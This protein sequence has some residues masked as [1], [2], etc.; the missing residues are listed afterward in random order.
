VFGSARYGESHP[1]YALG[2]ETGPGAREIDFTI[3]TGGGPWADGGAVVWLASGPRRKGGD[4]LWAVARAPAIRVSVSACA[5]PSPSHENPLTDEPAR[6]LDAVQRQPRMIRC[7]VVHR[8]HTLTLQS[9]PNPIV[10]APEP[11]DELC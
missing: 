10:V 3:M 2:P 6:A 8:E 9:H 5:V 7:E 4:G 11:V 1:Y